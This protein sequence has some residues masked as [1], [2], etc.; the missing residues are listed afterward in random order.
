MVKKESTNKSTCAIGDHIWLVEGEA[1]WGIYDLMLHQLIRIDKQSGRILHLLAQSDIEYEVKIKLLNKLSKLVIL[2]NVYKLSERLFKKDTSVKR[3]SVPL[4]LLWLEVTDTCNQQ[5]IHCYAE[6]RPE[7]KTRIRLDKALNWIREGKECGFREIQFTGGEPFTH[8]NLWKMVTYAKELGY[9][10]IEIYTNLT[11]T[12]YNDLLRMKKLGV[13]VATSL[14]GPNSEVHDNCTRTPGSFKNWYKN[15]KIAQSIG[16]TYRIGIIRMRQNENSI[17]SI[18][19]FLRAE[20][21]ISPS[22]P[23]NA[24]DARPTGLGSNIH[25]MPSVP[26]DYGL[27]LHINTTFFHTSRHYNPCWKGIIAITPMGDVYP[28]VFARDLTAG[29]LN[30]KPMKTIIKNLADTYWKITLDQVDRCRDCEFR[31][32]CMDCRPLTLNYPKSLYGAPVRCNG[33]KIKNNGVKNN[34]VKNNG[35]KS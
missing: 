33:S 25:V 8:K 28:C 29:N 13:N 17:S 30:E 1:K 5:C 26:Q 32:A 10:E 7:R 4:K 14:L 20:Q 19:A 22:D 34:G 11:L 21:L 9:P 35:V 15:I 12:K 16:L 18:E 2:C 3:V 6:S 27:N 24:T 23:F 31:Y